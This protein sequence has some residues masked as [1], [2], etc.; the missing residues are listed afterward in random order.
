MIYFLAAIIIVLV[1]IILL[2]YN[3]TKQLEETIDDERIE[4]KSDLKEALQ[5]NKAPV[6]RATKKK[7]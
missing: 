2:F 3:H 5:K 4:H 7:K 1:I 6:K